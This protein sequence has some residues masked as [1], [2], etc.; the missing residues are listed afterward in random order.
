V[1][2]PPSTPSI[3]TEPK[4]SSAWRA[5][6]EVLIVL[7]TA[8]VLSVVVRTFFVQ[9]FY[10]P[11]QSMENTLLPSDRILA[12]KITT[13]MFGVKR[14]QIVVFKDPGGWLPPAMELK[15]TPLRQ[16]LEFI[17][18]VPANKGDDLVKRVIAI[19]GDRISCCDSQGRIVLNGV[20]LDEPYIK[21]GVST[22]QVPFDVQ[23]PEGTVFVMGDNRAESADSRFHLDVANG[24]VPVDN[25]VGRVFLNVWPFSRINTFPVPKVPFANPALNNQPTSVEVTPPSAAATP[26]AAAAA[27]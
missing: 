20:P 27:P 24:G 6:R 19:G 18:V 8:V 21:P 15:G 13:N 16:A 9:A 23:V 7:V 14:G 25:V 5:V 22:D 11:S 3:P 10:V 12:S 26:A 1:T 2:S 4:G 17:G